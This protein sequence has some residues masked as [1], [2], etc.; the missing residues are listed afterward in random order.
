MSENDVA[1]ADGDGNVR[2]DAL[3]VYGKFFVQAE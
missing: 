3:Y 2:L 1:V